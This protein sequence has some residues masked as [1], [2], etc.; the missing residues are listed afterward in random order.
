[1]RSSFPWITSG[2]DVFLT[3][4]WHTT[5]YGE[6]MKNGIHLIDP[7]GVVAESLV[8]SGLTWRSIKSTSYDILA[9]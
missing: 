8:E 3:W 6:E 4:Y 7:N 5:G 9:S 2:D 1:M